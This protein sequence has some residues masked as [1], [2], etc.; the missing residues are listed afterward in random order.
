MLATGHQVLGFTFGVIAITILQQ[1][2]IAPVHTMDVILFFVFVLF[3]A[4]LPDI[5]TPASRLGSK[6]W[7]LLILLF[8]ITLLA[9]LFFPHVLDTYREDLK[10]FVMMMIPILV[11]LRGHRKM[12]H[13]ILF[14]MVMWVYCQVIVE[15]MHVPWFYLY[16]LLAGAVSHLLG[17]YVTKKGIPIFY[18][19]S[20]RHFRFIFTFRTGS[21]TEKTIVTVLVIYNVWVLIMNAT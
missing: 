9:Y 6:F 5:D 17:D 16:G 8:L 10:I 18:P 15:W 4:L 13:S 7:R 20:K 12:T 11:M 2:G 19:I 1:F 14:L 21:V 3:G